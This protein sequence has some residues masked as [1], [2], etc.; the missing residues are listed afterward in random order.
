M[1]FPSIR[2]SLLKSIYAHKIA[3][4]ALKTA[5]IIRIWLDS[6]NIREPLKIGIW[7]ATINY[8][9]MARNGIQEQP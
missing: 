5:I 1:Y 8:G 3:F 2:N 6:N 9:L 7:R 4:K